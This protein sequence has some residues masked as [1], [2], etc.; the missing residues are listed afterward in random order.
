M[1]LVAEFVFRFLKFLDSRA[2][3]A[4]EFRQFL[5]AEENEN[6]QEDDDQVGSAE[7]P[8]ESEQAHEGKHLLHLAKLQGNSW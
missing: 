4:S 8:Q 2:H 5:R 3:A 6:D 7:V 1:Q